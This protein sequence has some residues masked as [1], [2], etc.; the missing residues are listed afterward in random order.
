MAT[1]TLNKLKEK[2]SKHSDK[3]ALEEYY[4]EMQAAENSGF[5]SFEDHKKNMNEW[6]KTKL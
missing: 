1:A 2:I 3:V 4:R 6:L 5:I